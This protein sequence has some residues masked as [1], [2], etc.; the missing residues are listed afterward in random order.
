MDLADLQNPPPRRYLRARILART[1]ASAGAVVTACREGD[2][3]GESEV[4][5]D[6]GVEDRAGVTLGDRGYTLVWSPYLWHGASAAAMNLVRMVR[7]LSGE[8]RAHTHHT[9]FHNETCPHRIDLKLS[10]RPKCL[11]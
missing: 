10:Y 11:Q 6:A 7:W 8:Q 3:D 1:P 4:P 9:P 2:A 5:I